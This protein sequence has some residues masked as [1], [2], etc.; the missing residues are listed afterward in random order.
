V[1]SLELAPS[2]ARQRRQPGDSELHQK[3]T[4]NLQQA[5]WLFTPSPTPF[6]RL[7][8]TLPCQWASRGQF[9]TEPVRAV[10]VTMA[11][12]SPSPHKPRRKPK[13]GST[14][15]GV[16]I[17]DN[18]TRTRSETLVR[19]PSF[20]LAAFLWP[21]RTSS[22][23][24]EVLPAVLMVV[25]LFRWAAGLWGYSGELPLGCHRAICPWS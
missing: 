25:G 16:G 13:S 10:A 4:P 14:T 9:R 7:C 21:A 2:L 24:W 20:P 3:R 12:A 15:N 8:H 18:V 6:P 19:A 22:T 1:T 17:G 11:G 23:Q 5:I